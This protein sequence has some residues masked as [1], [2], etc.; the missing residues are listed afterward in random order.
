MR[1][2]YENLKIQNKYLI[3]IW[4]VLCVKF[5]P[6]NFLNGRKV[7]IKKNCLKICSSTI[8]ALAIIK[9]N[10]IQQRLTNN[11]SE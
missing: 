3:Q 4:N 1:S 10:Q 8:K 9:P 6:P 5:N 2:T 11:F 7:I